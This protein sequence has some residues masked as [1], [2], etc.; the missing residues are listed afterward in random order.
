VLTLIVV[1]QVITGET[2]L[3]TLWSLMAVLMSLAL[4]NRRFAKLGIPP[5]IYQHSSANQ[6]I[7]PSEPDDMP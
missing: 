5:G 2:L 3:L 7:T 1:V 4:T 6:S